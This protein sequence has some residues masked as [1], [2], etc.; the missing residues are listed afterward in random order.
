M[1]KKNLSFILPLNDDL[2]LLVN[3]HAAALTIQYMWKR[4]VT[5]EYEILDIILDLEYK[6]YSSVHT[7]F[8]ISITDL[9]AR[10]L[11]FAVS[12]LGK[13]SFK[14]TVKMWHTILLIVRWGIVDA[15]RSNN[16]FSNTFLRILTSY[17]FLTKRIDQRIGK[18]LN[19]LLK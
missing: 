1:S 13:H 4:Y 14:P 11:E 12:K 7:Y 15:L 19:K 10:L 17:K 16:H 9:N 5:I 3:D 6:T 2:C 8:G 18:R